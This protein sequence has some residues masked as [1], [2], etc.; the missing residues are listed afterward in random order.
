MKRQTRNIALAL[1][2]TVA[3]L[4]RIMRNRPGDSATGAISAITSARSRLPAE[5]HGQ[6]SGTFC[7]QALSVVVPNPS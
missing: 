7:G 4:V 3:S 6:V 1:L 2:L 5:A